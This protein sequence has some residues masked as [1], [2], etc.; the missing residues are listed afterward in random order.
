MTSSSIGVEL[1]CSFVFLTSPTES[2]YNCKVSS[3]L[4]IDQRNTSIEKVVGTHLN[5]RINNE[6]V[7]RLFFSN[8]REMKFI[9]T[10]Y[11]IF[12]PN[13]DNLWIINSPL[14]LIER[15][16][17]EKPKN[18]IILGIKNTNIAM[19][20]RKDFWDLSNLLQLH[21]SNNL[22]K[23]IHGESFSK[24]IALEILNL[25]DNKL[26]YLN[27]SLFTEN[28]Q[29][30]E[31]YISGNKL[32]I[33]ESQTF[34]G[35]KKVL[36]IDLSRNFCI[37]K[38]FPLHVTMTQFNDAISEDC[39][40]PM[41]DVI[42]DLKESALGSE[43]IIAELEIEKIKFIKELTIKNNKI[44]EVNGDNEDLHVEIRTMADEKDAIFIEK[45]TLEEELVLL[46]LN[47]SEAKIKLDEVFNHTIELKINLLETKSKLNET[48]EKADELS[49]EVDHLKEIIDWFKWNSS[50]IAAENEYLIGNVTMIHEQLIQVVENKSEL[51]F[52][53]FRM[54]ENILELEYKNDH[55]ERKANDIF[56][57]AI[58][59]VTF[60]VVIIMLLGM[61]TIRMLTI[62]KVHYYCTSEMEAVFSKNELSDEHGVT[63]SHEQS[64][65]FP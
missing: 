58:A 15:T 62:K 17:F 1:F 60:L 34:I 7:T 9:P 32:K 43:R 63:H 45:E 36:K 53:N 12:F 38:K 31:I 19:I 10:G 42:E 46:G 33:I 8:N 18:L 64:L 41:A 4:Q 47:H 23:Q 6:R 61:M 11:S 14:E 20:S 37:S 28:V 52:E 5:Y 40:N 39:D 24:L 35:L 49:L 54:S 27:A 56:L 26:S 3:K 29:L 30:K 51:Q 22:I 59:T 48:F 25:A 13:L 21:I 2:G 50:S 16:D 65:S 57:I 44:I 55:L